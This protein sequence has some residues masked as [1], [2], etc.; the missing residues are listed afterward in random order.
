MN[1]EELLRGAQV[2][3]AGEMPPAGELASGFAALDALLPGGGWPLPALTEVLC[4]DEGIGALR[5]LLPALAALSR[6]GQWLIWISPPHI[7]YAPALAAAGVDLA[8][9][10]IVEADAAAERRDGEERLWA[11]EQALRFPDCG[12]ALAWL[13]TVDSLRLRRLQ[14]ACEAGQSLGVMFRPSR[15]AA[16]ASPASLRLKLT[17]AAPGTLEVDVLKCRGRLR[18]RSCT[19]AL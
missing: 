13:A 9:L 16:E 14:L 4:D 1:L 5:L 2:R 11:F 15:H 17:P 10:L 8:R 19:L 18:A 12:A 7:P 6:R 3:R